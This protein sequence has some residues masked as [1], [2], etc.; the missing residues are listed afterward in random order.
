[1][2]NLRTVWG[3]SN[4]CEENKTMDVLFAATAL[5]GDGDVW[6]PVSEAS[7]REDLALDVTPLH[8]S[9]VLL[10]DD[11]PNGSDSTKVADLVA[12]ESWYWQPCFGD[13]HGSYSTLRNL[14]GAH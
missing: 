1:M 3:G 2:A 5:G 10:D 14:V 13:L 9:G 8:M 11:S 12:V 7:E 4:E 6:V